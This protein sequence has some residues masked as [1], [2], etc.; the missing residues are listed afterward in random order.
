[1]FCLGSLFFT[2]MLQNAPSC[3][4]RLNGMRGDECSDFKNLIG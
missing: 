3:L 2:K 4:S 1:M